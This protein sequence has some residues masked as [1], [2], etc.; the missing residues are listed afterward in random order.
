MAEKQSNHPTTTQPPAKLEIEASTSSE[1]EKEQESAPL[2]SEE[3]TENETHT[4]S[5]NRII[6]CLQQLCCWSS[7]SYAQLRGRHDGTHFLPPY[8]S[9][10]TAL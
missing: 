1:E 3:E 2:S 6:S 8:P 5:H 4:V 9:G 7:T 10:T